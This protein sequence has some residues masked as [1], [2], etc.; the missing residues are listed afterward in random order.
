M[1]QDNPRQ[2]LGS[3]EVPWAWL[4]GLL[5]SSVGQSSIL[6]WRTLRRPLPAL[7]AAAPSWLRYCPVLLLVLA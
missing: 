7:A 5:P 4:G 6:W 3:V 1:L 2:L